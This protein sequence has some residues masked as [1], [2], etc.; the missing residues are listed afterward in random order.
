MINKIKDK[1]KDIGVSVKIIEESYTSKCDA[2]SN[3]PMRFKKTYLGKRIYRG[4]FSSAKN[5]LINAD[6]NGAINIMRKVYCDF[7]NTCIEIFN[8]IRINIFH[9]AS[10]QWIT[11]NSTLNAL[12]PII[13]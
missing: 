11:G 10:C 13:F 5:K 7:K 3:E 12:T 8:P 1:F 9:E 4:L 2:L 6:I